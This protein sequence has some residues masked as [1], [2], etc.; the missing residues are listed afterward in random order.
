[1]KSSSKLSHSG[2]QTVKE[3]CEITD[4]RIEQDNNSEKD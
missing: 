3:I 4:V 1:M 2:F